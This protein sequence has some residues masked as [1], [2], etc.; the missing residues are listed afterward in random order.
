MPVLV[1]FLPLIMKN[2]FEKLALYRRIG[3]N[4]PLVSDGLK[5]FLNTE[6]MILK[7]QKATENLFIRHLN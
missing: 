6:N 3:V 5:V 2:G 1:F 4:T 7:F